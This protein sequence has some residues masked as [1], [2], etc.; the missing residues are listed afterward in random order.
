MKQH[1]YLIMAHMENEI[2]RQLLCQLDDPRN[3]IFLHM[4][5]K[6]P[7][8]GSCYEQVLRHAKL[9]RVPRMD[10]RWGAYSQVSCEVLLLQ[11]ATAY[12]TFAY[13]HLLSGDSLALQPQEAIHQFFTRH[14]GKEFVQFQ[15]AEL[16]EETL[17]RIRYYYP[18]TPFNKARPV[19]VIKQ[20][21][22]R[23]QRMLGVDRLKKADFR[24]QKGGSWVSIT[25]GLARYIL[26]Q[27]PWFA[28]RFKHTYAPDEF[29]IQT[30]VENSS[31]KDA[32]Y[33]QTYSDS[34]R[35]CLRYI[36]WSQTHFGPLPLAVADLYAMQESGCLFARKF[37][38]KDKELVEK[39]T[40]L[41]QAEEEEQSDDS[42]TYRVDRSLHL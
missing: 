18:E 3:V 12:G 11:A 22:L 27:E 16:T 25:D 42:S 8:D 9:Q 33:D 39:I 15:C 37:S 5:E 13:Y 36:K 41:T 31:Y 21:G 17:E 38:P 19:R 28:Q 24:P 2:L 23:L 26:Q 10:V 35:S 29:F 7:R 34:P 30:I 4:D 32:V 6:S 1:A 14:D 40:Q 20:L